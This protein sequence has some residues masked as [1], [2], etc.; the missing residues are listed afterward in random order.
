MLSSLKHHIAPTI[1][2]QQA[3]PVKSNQNNSILAMQTVLGNPQKHSPILTSTGL[4]HT[5]IISNSSAGGGGQNNI[6]LAV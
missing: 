3:V 2:G 5:H 4:E 6:T 1:T